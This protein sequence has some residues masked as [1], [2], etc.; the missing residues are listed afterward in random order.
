MPLPDDDAR[1]L[2]FQPRPQTLAVNHAIPGVTAITRSWRADEVHLC[3]LCPQGECSADRN[4]YCTV[5]VPDVIPPRE[6]PL[7]S[8]AAW[9]EMQR[10]AAGRVVLYG[11]PAG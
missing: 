5:A 9:R 11:G 2:P 6:C 1:V 8:L 7:F 4:G 3:R 10:F